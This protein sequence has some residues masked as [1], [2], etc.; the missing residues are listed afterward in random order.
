M[1]ADKVAVP[2][3]NSK[4]TCALGRINSK[5]AAFRLLRFYSIFDATEMI[6]PQRIQSNMACFQPFLK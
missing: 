5:T 6:S 3:A 4:N 1:Q 2:A